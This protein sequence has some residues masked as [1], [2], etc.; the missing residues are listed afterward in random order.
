MLERT[1]SSGTLDG[2][3][4]VALGGQMHHRVGLV[5][6]ENR[7]QLGPVADVDVLEGVAR[8]IRHGRHVLE[9]GRVGQRVQV[10][11]LV[12]IGDGAAHH[13]GADE[14]GAAGDQD[15]QLNPPGLEN[16]GFLTLKTRPFKALQ[17]P[18][19]A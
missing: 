13:G 12:A 18:Q 10:H 15:L 4:V 19:E 1:K 9:V 14:P 7:F 5:F 17:S 8:L 11:H 3:V 2:A 16:D 6:R